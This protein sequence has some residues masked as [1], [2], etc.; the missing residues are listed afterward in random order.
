MMRA[1]LPTA[2][3]SGGTSSRTTAP[4]PTLAPAPISTP[5]PMVA[6]PPIVT[7]N[8]FSKLVLALFT[9]GGAVLCGFVECGNSNFTTRR[10]ANHS[11]L[12]GMFL[13]LL[14]ITRERDTTSSAMKRVRV[15]SP[16]LLK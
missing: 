7:L 9:H 3:M 2:I 16:S 14:R 6:N 12:E 15:V 10:R 1:G 8:I 13:P 11:M 4:T 5:H